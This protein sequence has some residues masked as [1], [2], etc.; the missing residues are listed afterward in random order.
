WAEGDVRARRARRLGAIVLAER[1]LADPAPA[2][3]RDALLTGLRAAGTGLLRWDADA[4][5][6]RQRMG[7]LHRVLGEP[8]PAVDERALLH[9]VDAWLG[10]ELG[11]ARRR[12]DLE[13]IDAGA[14]LRRLLP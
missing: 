13:R 7:F 8:W 3:V 1:P 4:V 10:P 6:L 9:D 2:A 12:A 14:A 5:R 11:T